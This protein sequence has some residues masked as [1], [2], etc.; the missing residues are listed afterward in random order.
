MVTCATVYMLFGI[1]STFTYYD[2]G[3]KVT[4]FCL[5]ITPLSDF[6]STILMASALYHVVNATKK[7][8]KANF[9]VDTWTSLLH[10]V[11][12]SIQTVSYGVFIYY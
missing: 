3:Y 4:V 8:N 1:I 12:L 5:L 10:V 7:A 2:L 11:C 9:K 6:V